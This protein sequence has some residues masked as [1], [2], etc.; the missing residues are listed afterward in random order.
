MSLCGPYVYKDSINFCPCW[1]F[2][3]LQKFTYNKH[4]KDYLEDAAI[5]AR[6]FHLWTGILSGTAD[7]VSLHKKMCDFF[8]FLIF[9]TVFCLGSSYSGEEWILSKILVRQFEV[10]PQLLSQMYLLILPSQLPRL[11]L[12]FLKPLSTRWSEWTYPKL[13]C[14]KVS[15]SF[16]WPLGWSWVLSAWETTPYPSCLSPQQHW[17]LNISQAAPQKPF[18]KFKWSVT[19]LRS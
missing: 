10:I 1:S 11:P 6:P 2:K 17:S 15:N 9:T 5:R 4:P 8:F 13:L 12:Y 16:P 7:F 3:K 14:L 18:L 19:H